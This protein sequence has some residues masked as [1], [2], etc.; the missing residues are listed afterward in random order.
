MRIG[1]DRETNWLVFDH[2]PKIASSERVNPKKVLPASPRKM[3][4]DFPNLKL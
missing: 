4:A 1:A 2:F 3:R